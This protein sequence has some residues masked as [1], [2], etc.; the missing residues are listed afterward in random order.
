MSNFL[1]VGSVGKAHGLKGELH[2]RLLTNRTERLDEQSALVCDGR[3]LHVEKARPNGPTFLVKF[4][5]VN[6]RNTAEQLKGAEL[7]AEPIADPDELWVHELIGAEVV[8]ALHGR[9]GVVVEMLENPAS[10]LL[11]LDNERLIPARFITSFENGV[12]EVATPPG[13]YEV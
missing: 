2:V 9:I 8:D 6:D 7:L 5:E 10:D 4:V 11:V 12:I 1:I 13:L 3:T